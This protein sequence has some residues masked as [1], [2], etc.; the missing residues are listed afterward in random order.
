MD[1]HKERVPLRFGGGGHNNNDTVLL[2]LQQVP[3]GAQIPRH[4]LMFKII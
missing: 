1:M 2:Q 3:G 4:F